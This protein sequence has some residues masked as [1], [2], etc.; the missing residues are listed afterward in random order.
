MNT[1]EGVV[2]F[3]NV[4]QHDVYNGQSTGKY[5]VTITMDDEAAAETY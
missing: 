4:T 3:S 1:I 2:A 5:S